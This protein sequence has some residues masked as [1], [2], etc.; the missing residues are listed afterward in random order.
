MIQNKTYHLC[1]EDR[2]LSY[3]ISKW[4]GED[5]P[6]PFT[7]RNAGKGVDGSFVV[8]IQDRDGAML[9]FIA[10]IVANTRA[11]VRATSK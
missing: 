4:K 11:K 7:L 8:S 3:F 2:F 10:T 5:K 1:I 6:F 9:D